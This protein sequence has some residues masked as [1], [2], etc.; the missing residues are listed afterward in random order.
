MYS[1]NVN[2]RVCVNGR[3]V[4]E[5]RHDGLLF[6][7]S[8]HG[9]NYSIKI[10]NDNGYRVMAIVSV[11]GLD[12]ITGK[13]AE[14]T[15]TGYIVDS[16]SSTEIKGYRISDT[17]SAAFVFSSKGESYVANVQ[18]GDV[19]NSGVIGVRVIREKERATDNHWV[20]W[21]D[22]IPASVPSPTPIPRPDPWKPY[23][24]YW[25]DMKGGAVYGATS[26]DVPV[27]AS[28]KGVGKSLLSSCTT[29]GEDT[30]RSFNCS[31]QSNASNNAFDM[32]QLTTDSFDTGTAWGEQQKDKVRHVVFERG[33][34]IAE[35]VLYYSSARA[36]EK[37]G[38]D[39][40]DTP[41][42]AEPAKDQ[43]PKPFGRTDYCTPPKNWKRNA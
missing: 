6:I 41:A 15:P 33:E 14:E 31:V 1:K 24:P 30:V 2:V 7:E 37:M 18:S 28:V 4:K 16:Y 36:L 43:L 22:I 19:R 42:V 35:L 21:K 25:Y 3:P 38:I 5:Y 40:S 32:N 29:A 13:P 34:Q 26:G 17:E 10:T 39:L 12:V 8:R 20:E 11:D 9:T 27:V 23:Q